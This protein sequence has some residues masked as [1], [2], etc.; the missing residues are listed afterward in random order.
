LAYPP[1]QRALELFG[2]ALFPVLFGIS[3]S[4]LQGSGVELLAAALLGWLAADLL[5]GL[6][7]WAL[8]RF[9]SERT[10]AIG[11]VLIR[12]FREHHEDALAMTRHDFVETNGA[13]ALGASVLLL[14]GNEILFF[15][16][17]GV[18][19]ANQC[20]KWAH[21]RSVPALVRAAQ[22]LRLILPP[23]AHR[24]HHAAP[25]DRHYCTASG[26]MNRPLDFILSRC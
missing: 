16:A 22:R 4:S 9:G 14:F 20:H 15:T 5:S 1:A 10:P 6:V 19:A 13:S 26:W 3:A 8:D 23:E 25:H 17:L 21:Q 18:L 12:P 11:A 7:H 24:R 2:I